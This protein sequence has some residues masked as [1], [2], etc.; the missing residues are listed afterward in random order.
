MGLP[1]FF[2]R[3]ELNLRILQKIM[4]DISGALVNSVIRA[5]TFNP[6]DSKPND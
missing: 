2:I 3:S 6:P 4:V 1:L 5:K